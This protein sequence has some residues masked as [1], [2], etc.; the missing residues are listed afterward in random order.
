MNSTNNIEPKYTR[1]CPNCGNPEM[2]MVDYP[3]LVPRWRCNSCL[4]THDAD[5]SEIST[6]FDLKIKWI[7][8]GLETEKS[9]IE[10]QEEPTMKVSYNGFTGELVKMERKKENIPVVIYDLI[11][12]ETEKKV[13]HSFADVTLNDVKF[14]GG[15]VSFD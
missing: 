5:K 1:R 11:I 8:N 15:S 6:Y 9:I 2:E 13:T 12:Y 4:V 3:F 7:K 14:L 10:K